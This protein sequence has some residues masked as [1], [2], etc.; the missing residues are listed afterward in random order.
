VSAAATPSRRDVGLNALFLGFFASAWFGWAQAEPAGSL[1]PWLNAGSVAAL[2]AAVAGAVIGFRQPADTSAL[3]VPGAG[4]RYG[5]IVGI[6]FG[7]AGVGAA[8]LAVTGATDY[9][10][11]W[12]CAVVGV[13]FFPLA[14]VL[15]DRWLYPLGAALC[16]VALAGLIVALTTTTAAS[17]VVGAGAGVLLLASAAAPLPYRGRAPRTS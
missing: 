13:H 5:I 11:V 6:E 8:V 2:L 10:P 14:P 9:I 1:T 15:R 4:R 17:L 3:R 12:I 7:L 16:L